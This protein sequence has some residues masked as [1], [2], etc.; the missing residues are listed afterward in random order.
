MSNRYCDL[1][2][3]ASK[4]VAVSVWPIPVAVCT[5]FNSWWWTERPSET[6]TV[7]IQNKSICETCA[8]SWFTIEILEIRRHRRENNIEKV[9]KWVELETTDW[10]LLCQDLEQCLAV[11]NTVKDAWLLD[12]RK[13][14]YQGRVC[15][16]VF[17]CFFVILSVFYSVL[18]LI[19]HIFLSERELWPHSENR[20]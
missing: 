3:P 4:Q 1:P 11:M 20:A 6:R 2:V 7:S 12:V 5:F 16:V 19:L 10:I 9:A 14:A 13:S 8:S 17:V 18:Q 15:S